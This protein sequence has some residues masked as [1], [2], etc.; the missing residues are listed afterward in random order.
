MSDDRPCQMPLEDTK[1]FSPSF[2]IWSFPWSLLWS[3]LDI[4]NFILKVKSAKFG[5]GRFPAIWS[6]TGVGGL[7]GMPKVFLYLFSSRDVKISVRPLVEIF[8]SWKTS[9]SQFLVKDVFRRSGLRLMSE[10]QP[11]HGP[12]KD[13]RNLL[14]SS[15]VSE[16]SVLF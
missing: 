6:E 1:G 2:S 12:L 5:H 14:P 4:E 16:I 9:I 10:V 15:L 13:A 7:P 8:G 3:F 11:Y